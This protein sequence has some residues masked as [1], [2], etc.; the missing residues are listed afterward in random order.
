MAN[1]NPI[2]I[3]DTGEYPE[4]IITKAFKEN[5]LFVTTTSELL[6]EGWEL[7]L[8]HALS[9]AG[10]PVDFDPQP[11]IIHQAIGKLESLDTK[12][13]ALASIHSRIRNGA[14]GKPSK[15]R[16]TLKLEANNELIGEYSL[17]STEK[18]PV[19][20]YTKIT[21]KLQ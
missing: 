3:T 7:D 9:I 10:K 1:Q 12:R 17:T 6:K 5:T 21:I 20:F 15:V 4:F 16:Y 11:D 14:E 19:T 18:N 8:I 2:K 13:F